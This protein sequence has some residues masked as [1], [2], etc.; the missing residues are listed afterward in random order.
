[1]HDAGKSLR[2]AVKGKN[3]RINSDM[4]EKLGTTTYTVEEQ[5]ILVELLAH[6]KAASNDSR[7]KDTLNETG[8]DYLAELN[9]KN[10][11][12]KHAKN[13]IATMDRCESIAFEIEENKKPRAIVVSQDGSC[14]ISAAL[15]TVNSVIYAGMDRVDYSKIK[16]EINRIV[17]EMKEDRDRVYSALWNDTKIDYADI[18]FEAYCNRFGTG[19]EYG[20]EVCLQAMANLHQIKIL[21]MTLYCEDRGTKITNVPW[22]L[23]KKICPSK[24]MKSTGIVVIHCIH[25]LSDAHYMGVA[26]VT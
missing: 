12:K 20:G 24:E 7:V 26:N 25:R 21:V 13:L 23:A 8:R 1:M 10:A 9:E 6:Q 3:I 17:T 5:E 16:K 22:N 14:C 2:V 18:S 15:R 11:F 19:E 4:Y